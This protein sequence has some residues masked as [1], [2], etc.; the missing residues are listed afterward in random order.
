MAERLMIV[1][2]NPKCKSVGEPEFVPG[3][4]GPKKR[5]QSVMGP[6]GWHQGEGWLIGCGPAYAYNACSTECVGPAVTEILRQVR[7]AEEDRYR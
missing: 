3:R 1:C 2:D 5:G 4:E 6:Y 7:Q